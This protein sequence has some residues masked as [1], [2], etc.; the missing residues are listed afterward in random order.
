VVAAVIYPEQ[1]ELPDQLLLVSPD[2]AW[3]QAVESAL[4]GNGADLNL[5]PQWAEDLQQLPDLLRAP[6]RLWLV[7]ECWLA[8]ALAQRRTY[9]WAHK[10]TPDL[11]VRF[12]TAADANVV[13]MIEMGARGCLSHSADLGEVLRALQAVLAGELW[14]SRRVYSHLLTKLLDRHAARVVVDEEGDGLT[15]RQHEIA[16]CVA[17]GMSNKQI[18]RH[19][20]ISPTT[21]KTHLH[22]IFERMGVSGRTLLALRAVEGEAH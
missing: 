14:V 15:E 18:A 5:R 13:P 16:A 3:C 12:E 7:D 17:R 9:T 8:P 4:A 11:I 2:R 10:P 19:L 22:N 6:S 20:G 21:V 1:G